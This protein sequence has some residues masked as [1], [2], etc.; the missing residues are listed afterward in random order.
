MENTSVNPPPLPGKSKE[1]LSTGKK[2]LIGCGIGCGVIVLLSLL[3][4]G[5]TVWW[6]LTPGDQVSTTRILGPDSLGAIKVRN[7]SENQGVM[8]FITFFFQE[9][10][11]YEDRGSSAE[12]PQFIEKIR[13][14]QQSRQNPAQWLKYLAPREI[15]LSVNSDD[16]GTA[17]FVVAANLNMG[18]RMVKTAFKIFSSVDEENEENIIS[19]PNGD[20]IK[21]D[22]RDPETGT[23]INKGVVGF[24]KGTILFSDD[25]TSAKSGLERLVHGDDSG[26]LRISL[27][28]PFDALK[29]GE[30]L[31]YGVLDG[32]F[33]RKTD[34]GQN[35]LQD[36]L[37]SQIEDMSAGANVQS[38]D[39]VFISI[40]IDWRT[41]EA[42]QM[43]VRR[44]EAQKAEWIE[45]TFRRG[46]RLDVKNTL[47]GEKQRI[48]FE[49]NNLK[50]AVIKSFMNL[51]VEEGGG[52]S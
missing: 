36:E 38:A 28:E 24:H 16:L 9:A 39:Q 19:T 11:K 6:I 37:L 26:E 35:I 34:L 27:E 22:D 41:E 30:W 5:L 40:N 18:A 42:A 3:I 13:Q 51:E 33:W 20:L 7:I 52:S 17:H 10:Q 50:D 25:I 47:T 49:L 46:L 48:E 21:L 31:A 1:K 23:K 15:T 44:V 43:A 2:V 12:L 29:V 45:K 14:Y 4:G 8:E 32:E